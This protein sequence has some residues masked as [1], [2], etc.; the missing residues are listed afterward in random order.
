MF[1]GTSPQL[2]ALKPDRKCVLFYEASN[3]CL[4]VR[5][6]SFVL[7]LANEFTHF[8]SI[9][10]W[11][12]AHSITLSSILALLTCRQICHRA[13]FFASLTLPFEGSVS[14]SAQGLVS[15]R[16]TAL[17]G[18]HGKPG[19]ASAVALFVPVVYFVDLGRYPC[20]CTYS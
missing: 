2:L 4:R 13:P 3:L 15:T 16:R 6:P 20:P 17:Q 1:N 7:A 8:F 12:C 18:F 9:C 11:V 14:S 5:T 19:D 10:V